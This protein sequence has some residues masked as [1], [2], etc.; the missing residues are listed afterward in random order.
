M[1]TKARQDLVAMVHCMLRYSA[2]PKAIPQ[3]LI[4]N[5]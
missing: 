5:A 3:A 1:G 2:I 4:A